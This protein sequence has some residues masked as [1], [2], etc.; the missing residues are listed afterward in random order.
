ML[1]LKS[2]TAIAGLILVAFVAGRGG[3]RGRPLQA[4]TGT[5]TALDYQE[6]T[7][8]INR[9]A[10]RYRHLREQWLRLR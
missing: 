5:L 6:I 8:L 2:V 10:S 3:F 1:Q 7:Q 9:Y 4:Q